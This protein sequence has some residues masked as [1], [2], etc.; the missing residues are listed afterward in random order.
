MLI[1]Q[2]IAMHTQAIMINV[3]ASSILS[4]WY[5]DSSKLVKAIFSLAAKIVAAGRFAMIF[6]DEVDAL[7]GDHLTETE[8]N[9]Q[10]RTE[11]LQMWDGL[12][13][14]RGIFVIGAT[15]QPQKLNDAV[16]RRFGS[17]F[18]VP[19]LTSPPSALV[20]VEAGTSYGQCAWCKLVLQMAY[21]HR[22]CFNRP[23]SR[24]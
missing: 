12:T 10:N 8:T 22:N 4:K 18:E 16:W 21:V 15:N 6:I 14:G 11:F 17:H 2:A 20:M 24:L 9:Q 13:T 7:L 1:L 23:F 19:L 5:G 3:T